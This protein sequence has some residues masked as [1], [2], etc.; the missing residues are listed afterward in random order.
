LTLTLYDSSVDP[1]QFFLNYNGFPLPSGYNFVTNN[2]S[3]D[4]NQNGQ[5]ADGYSIGYFDLQIP[6]G[7]N[8]SGNPFTTTLALFNGT[9]YLNLDPED[10]AVLSTNGALYSA[11]LQTKGN[12]WFGSTECGGCGDDVTPTPEPAS[13]LLFGSGLSAL[14]FRMRRRKQSSE[15]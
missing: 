13:L 5:Q 15:S 9:D 2:T 12:S 3:V 4:V 10:F 1:Q 11:V 8:I 14:A 6:D 7:G